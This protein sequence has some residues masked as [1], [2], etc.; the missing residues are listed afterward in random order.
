MSA[1]RFDPGTPFTLGE[2][3][4]AAEARQ[5]TARAFLAGIAPSAFVAPQGDRWSPAEHVRHLA[6]SAFAIATG[7][8]MPRVVLWL[9]F[10]WPR[11]RSRP[12]AQLVADYRA[13][14]AA[15]GQAGRFAPS[16]QDAD[17]DLAGYQQRVIAQWEAAHAAVASAARG[18]S[19]GAAEQAVITHPLIGAL[20][21]RE[22]LMF[23]HYHE[24][25]HLNL[26]ARRLGEGGA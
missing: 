13:A 2:I 22:M 20:T 23:Q 12:F 21:L 24:A 8:R 5:A 4:A 11:A 19:E 15:G 16:R 14:L 18:W 1:D 26:V 10:G 6:K 3:A 7:V 17:G 9:R 25:H